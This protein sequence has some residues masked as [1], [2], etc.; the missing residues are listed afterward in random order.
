MLPAEIMREKFVDSLWCFGMVGID[1]EGE[2]RKKPLEFALMQ[3]AKRCWQGILKLDFE[4]GTKREARAERRIG[5]IFGFELGESDFHDWAF[6]S[7]P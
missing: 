7:A 6:G 5:E 2:I 3:M 1:T 4:A